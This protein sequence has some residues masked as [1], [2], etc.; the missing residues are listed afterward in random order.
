MERTMLK[1]VVISDIHIATNDPTCWY[2][3]DYHEPYLI[4]VLD[5]IVANKDKIHELIILGDFFDFWTYPP[6]QRPP[7][8]E[9][10]LQANPAICGPQG[11]LREVLDAL[12]GRVS[13]VQGNHDLGITQDD[14]NKIGASAYKIRRVEDIYVSDSVVYTHGHLFTMFNA[15]DPDYALP[16]GHFVTRA[17]SYMIDRKRL[18]TLDLPNHGAPSNMRV[19]VLGSLLTRPDGFSLAALLLESLARHTGIPRDMPIVLPDG[20]AV[21]LNQA[22]RFYAALWTNWK[23]VYGFRGAYRAALADYDGSYMGWFAQKLTMEHGV[24]LAVMGHTHYPKLGLAVAMGDYLNT[25][26]VCPSRRD[27]ATKKRALT[28][29][30]IT[31]THDGPEGMLYQV[32]E[33]DGAYEIAPATAAPDRVGYST[34]GDYSCYVR[35]QNRSGHD[36]VLLD[37]RAHV[38]QFVVPPPHRIRAQS[39]ASFWLQDSIGQFGTA[40]S[41]TY[42]RSDGR[43]DIVL[44]FKCLALLGNRCSGADF[45]TRGKLGE[46]G[47]PGE[48][49]VEHPF[50]V[51]FTIQ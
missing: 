15:P 6:D 36:L 39:S 30:M 41:A 25:G 28:F 2:Q 23:N 20:Q 37:K 7:S 19:D 10:V 38:G 8:F 33:H 44:N 5:W 50:F 11:K 24:Q 16:V 29:A 42:T 12:Q 46:W 43:P 34:F 49:A 18:S 13:Y 17:I 1:T 31:H 9:S 21:T 3:K 27:M 47:A 51:E 40:G 48:I 22:K 32:V 35:L 45:R 26:F 14:L 4:A